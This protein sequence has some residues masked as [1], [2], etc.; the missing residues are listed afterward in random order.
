MWRLFILVGSV[1]VLA[2]L[3]ALR[4]AWLAYRPQRH[5]NSASLETRQLLV[6]QEAVNRQLQQANA[7][8]R[9]SEEKLAVTLNSIGDAV[10]ATDGQA[11]V[12][13]LNPVAEKLTGWTQSAAA[14]RPVGEVF[15]VVNKETRLP[16]TI[17]VIETLAHGTIQGLANHTVLI[18]ADGS[19]RDI[20]DSCAPIRDRDGRVVGAVLVFR[21][22]SEDYAAQQALRDSAAL[23]AAILNTVVD[24]IITLHSHGGIVETVNRPPSRCSATAQPTSSGRTSVC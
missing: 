17:P 22:V 6:T 2:L 11:R 3:L 7:T 12:T 16:G 23:V 4:S 15:R 1:G 24:G 19:E 20:A 18:A 9:D 8:L 13:R 5:R 10:I 14:G 21:D